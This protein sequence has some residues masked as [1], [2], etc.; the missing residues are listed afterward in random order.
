MTI[1]S[2]SWTATL[3]VR[4]YARRGQSGE[5]GDHEQNLE[6]PESTVGLN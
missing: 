6:H 2:S 4:V 5:H 1:G 3:T